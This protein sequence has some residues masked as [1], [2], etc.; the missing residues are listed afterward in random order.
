MANK[1]CLVLGSNSCAGSN[2]V[3]YAADHGAAVLATS[4]SVE[5]P[6]RYLAYEK[7]KI[8]FQRIDINSGM[9]GIK[10]AVHEFKPTDIINFASQSMVAES[11]EQPEDWIRTNNLGLLNLLKVLAEY[12]SL[13]SYIHYSTPEVYGNVTGRINESNIFN[14]STP[15]AATRAMGDYFVTMWHLMYGVPSIITRAGNIYGPGQRPYR[16]IPKTFLSILESRKLPL[17]G[18]GASKRN[19]VHGY[20]SAAAIWTL[21]AG[22]RP[23]HTYHISSDEYV[24]I[25]DLVSKIATMFSLQLSDVSAISPDRLGKDMNYSLG[26]Q[27][28]RD[29]GWSQTI[30]LEAGLRE[31]KT[32]IERDITHIQQSELHYVHTQ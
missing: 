32:M 18:G 19:F 22:G 28:L 30:P 3:K 23:G 12:D 25:A 21:M 11:W 31:V 13:R 7:G 6:Q 20:D 27:K 16:I 9:D 1:R 17:H 14:P 10:N 4:R 29:L 5:N 15:Y 2:F 26:D 8:D 24:S